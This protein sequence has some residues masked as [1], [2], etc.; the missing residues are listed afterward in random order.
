MVDIV[1]TIGERDRNGQEAMLLPVSADQSAQSACA[2]EPTL[3]SHLGSGAS[4]GEQYCERADRHL[5]FHGETDNEN[6]VLKM[7]KQVLVES[8]LIP[9]MTFWVTPRCDQASQERD[10]A[11]LRVIPFDVLQHTAMPVAPVVREDPPETRCGCT[12]HGTQPSPTL[13]RASAVR[14]LR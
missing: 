3:D 11:D 1:D 13:E 6:V 9:G 8:S 14:R 5:R 7:K 4:L 2:S 12:V 10:G